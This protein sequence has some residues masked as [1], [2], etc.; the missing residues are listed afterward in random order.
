MTHETRTKIQDPNKEDQRRKNKASR[1]SVCKL[2]TLDW[3]V[4][5]YFFFLEIF[6]VIGSWIL[7][8]GS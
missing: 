5:F 7:V 8:L 6:L 4:Y 1:C 2:R 3:F